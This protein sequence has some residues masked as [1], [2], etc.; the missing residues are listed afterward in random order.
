[1]EQ[2]LGIVIG[3]GFEK[4]SLLTS[5]VGAFSFYAAFYFATAEYFKALGAP[6]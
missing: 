3:N 6:P 2:S 5:N 4:K 1:M